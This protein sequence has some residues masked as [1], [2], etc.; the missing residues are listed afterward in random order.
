MQLGILAV[1][2]RGDS[3]RALL[4]GLVVVGAGIEVIL[5]QSAIRSVEA[6]AAAELAATLGV[7][8]A[9]SLG[10][11]VVFPLDQRFVGFSLTAGCTASLLAAP[12]FLIAAGLVATRRISIP[13]GL[14]TLGLVSVILF[15]VNQLRLLVIALSMRVWGFTTGYN[16]SHVLLGSLVSSVG[17]VVGL[18]LFV[19]AMVY[20]R[21]AQESHG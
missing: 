18:L 11:A 5:G 13:R 19:L 10:T 8:P 2:R 12:F 7:V 1:L 14:F 4:V 21:R 16:R 15:T 6:H 17:L 9:H 20:E 3:I